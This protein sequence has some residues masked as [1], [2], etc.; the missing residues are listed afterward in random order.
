LVVEV[1]TVAVIGTSRIVA[2][3]AEEKR[4]ERKSK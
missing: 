4:V 1:I 2:V 3:A